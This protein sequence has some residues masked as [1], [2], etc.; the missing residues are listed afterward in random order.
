MEITP[1]NSRRTK[2]KT[3]R[4]ILYSLNLKLYGRNVV[5]NFTKYKPTEELYLTLQ[6]RKYESTT[7]KGCLV[8]NALS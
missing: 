8:E 1:W 4:V 6:S 7:T 5:I 3:L 2:E